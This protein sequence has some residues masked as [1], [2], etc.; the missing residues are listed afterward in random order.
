MFPSALRWMASSMQARCGQRPTAKGP[1][2]CSQESVCGE[3]GAGDREVRRET[4]R[5]RGAQQN[6]A[7]VLIPI[8]SHHSPAERWACRANKEFGSR[9]NKLAHNADEK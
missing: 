5:Q 3:P 2:V 7:V 1:G 9:L 8:T 6:T 4:G